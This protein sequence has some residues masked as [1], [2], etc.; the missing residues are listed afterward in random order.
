M[1]TFRSRVL[2]L[3][4]VLVVT[5]QL[6]TVA[7][8]VFQANRRA[9]LQAGED[10][11][12][13][14]R[15]L[16]ALLQSR[17]E[18]LREAVRVLVADY[19]FKEAATLADADT[20][21]SALDNSAERVDAQLAV[22]LDTHG[23]VLA[24]TVP[25]LAKHTPAELQRL[26]F[27][28]ADAPI[29]RYLTLGDTTYMLVTTTVRAP[30]PVATAVLGFA[31]D[32]RL[33]ERL[34]NLL[35]YQVSFV[36]GSP[37]APIVAGSSLSGD[38]A[39][40]TQQLRLQG[41]EWSKPIVV[42]SGHEAY[43]TWLAPISGGG[44]NVHVVLQKPLDDALAPYKSMRTVILLVA[45]L[46]VVLAIPFA[47]KLAKQISRPLEKLA[48]AAR[49]IEGG[50]Y[51]EPVALDA[52]QEFVAVASTLDSMQRNIAE[53]EQRIR[54]Q[55]THDELTGLPNR[56]LATQELRECIARITDGR[57]T[58]ALL[59]VELKDFD[60][61]HASFGSTVGD[62][63][64]VEVARRLQTFAGKDYVIARVAIAQFLVIAPGLVLDAA[65]IKARHLLQSIRSGFM[66][67][68]LPIMLDAHVGLSMFPE[69]G[70]HAHELQRR[71]DTA[72]FDAKERAVAIA[73]YDP[74][75]DEQRRRQ[76][77]LLGDLRRALN[78]DELTL[79]YQPKVDMRSHTVRSLEALVRWNHPQ[80][81]R[82][83]PDEF[84]PLAERTGNVSLLTAWV[85]KKAL[86]Q[87]REWRAVG[88]EPDVSVNLSASDL[89]DPEIADFVIGQLKEFDTAPQRLVLEVTESAVMRETKSA[90]ATME[91]LRQHGVRF[92]V[93]DFGTGFSSLAQFKQ[94]PVDEIKIDKSFVLGL[95]PKSDD[96]VIVRSTIDLGHNLGVKVVAEG[97]ETPVAWR[98][99]LDLGCDLAQ[100]YLISRPVPAEEV[101]GRV[102]EI[103]ANM[104]SAETATQQ[105]RALRV[106]GK[107]TE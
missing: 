42:H 51:S 106:A 77:A 46:A 58:I 4:L 21:A 57:R 24:A 105:L 69:H 85:L 39:E 50:D 83:R 67:D 3:L 72:L 37:G 93:D 88:F 36:A 89:S 70:T 59:V 96:A 53:R 92:S 7:V 71:A 35:K 99:L 49:R 103:N 95:Q 43:M 47:L 81:G 74:A 87:M 41:I 14:A 60:Q 82:I 80:L 6:A 68:G 22:L 44:A 15:V 97:I 12:V 19:G 100:G 5:V 54:H 79:H 61:V 65:N 78:A 56:I 2:W 55:A 86:W 52:P 17:A 91:R 84:V 29:I 18:Q 25:R 104:M 90:I 98:M 32:A 38:H 28:A 33:A 75:R 63:L 76:L 16:D 107:R 66:S 9:E 64:L 31:V 8:L 40:L 102:R 30:T 48:R 23:R 62:A 26:A 73:V 13:G 34:S 1:T 20:L 27:D 11:Q 94:L 10:L 101:V 45:A